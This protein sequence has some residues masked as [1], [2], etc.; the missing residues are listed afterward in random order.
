LMIICRSVAIR[1]RITLLAPSASAL[2]IMLAICDDFAT[3]YISFNASKSKCLVVLP[4]NRRF[5]HDSLNNC[6]FYV[7][8]N[9][10]EYVDS[11][12]YLGHYYYSQLN[13]T[14]DI[15]QRR[16]DFVGRQ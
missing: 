9:R 8:N 4:G 7:G 5:L 13:D 15:L 12:T 1:G 6:P 2:R 14:A 11:F 16:N 3:E 10:I